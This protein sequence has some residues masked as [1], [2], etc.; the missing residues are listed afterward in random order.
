MSE[1]KKTNKKLWHD[2]TIAAQAL[3]DTL[4][5][6]FGVAT[7][8]IPSTNFVRHENG[9]CQDGW[10]YARAN[11]PNVEHVEDILTQLEK[12]E[13]A[14]AFS[15]GMAAI[16]TF[17]LSLKPG[18]HIVAAKDMYF[19]TRKWLVGF[20]QE[21]GLKVTL[22]DD[23]NDLDNLEQAILPGK[24]KIVWVESPNNPYWDLVD[25]EAISEVSHKHNCKVIVDS[26]AATPVHC[27]PILLGADYVL[28]SASK[29]LNGHGDVIGGVI[30]AK[31]KDEL[32]ELVQQRRRSHG[33]ILGSFAAWLLTRGLRTL[34]VRMKQSAQSAFKIAHYLNNHPDISCVYY[35]GLEDHPRHDLA[36]KQM[37]N[38]FGNV[39]SIRLKGGEEAAKQVVANTQL[40]LR[41][42][43]FGG[44]ESLIEHR[45][46]VEDP[47]ISEIPK[48]LL[49]ISVG[50]EDTQDL[51]KDIEHAL[52]RL[53]HNKVVGL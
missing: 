43:S 25:I 29:G 26:T 27:Q 24:T 34:V 3:G 22:V 23:M 40:F 16:T 47:T 7:P 18:D 9:D 20:G 42:T 48:D 35:M 38:G 30:I 33:C 31:E 19:V 28:H 1:Q 14:L 45:A 5:A 21:W 51:I 36:T 13:D 12:G 6:D 15:S 8:L 44:V 52:S 17:F 2:S 4:P 11:N 46:S 41:A 39:L 10:L 32:W 37:K 53:S 49:R 50:L